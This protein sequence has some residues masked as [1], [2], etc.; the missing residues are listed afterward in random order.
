MIPNLNIQAKCNEF[1]EYLKKNRSKCL[2]ILQA[3]HHIGNSLNEPSDRFFK[4][5]II[6][7]AYSTLLNEI[8]YVDQKG[9]DFLFRGI[10]IS[11]KSAKDAFQ[12]RNKTTSQLQIANTMGNNQGRNAKLQSDF[13]LLL[14]TRTTSPFAI[15]VCTHSTVANYCH[16]TTDQ[17]IAQIPFTDLDFVIDIT[18]QIK[19][20][21]TPKLNFKKEKDLMVERVINGLFKNMP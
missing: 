18:D 14:I 12:I 8:H 17:I 2:K 6:D 7:K 13:D 15:A 20:E 9:H 21:E 5:E 19:F 1:V 3:T 16:A 10:R 4:A 11:H